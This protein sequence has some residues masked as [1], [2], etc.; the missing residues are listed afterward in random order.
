MAEENKEVLVPGQ[1]REASKETQNVELDETRVREYL[2]TKYGIEDDPETFKKKRETWTQAETE[3]PKYQGALKQVYDY[4][5]LQANQ[6]ASTA[7]GIL[8]EEKL[9]QKALLDPYGATKEYVEYRDKQYNKQVEEREERLL[10]RINEAIGG[11]RSAEAGRTRLMR[12]WPEAYD[13]NSELHKLGKSIYHNELSP[14]VRS[15]PDS[16][17]IAAE[18]AAARLGLAPKGKRETRQVRD[19]ED[20]GSQNIGRQTRKPNNTEND[21]SSRLS[22]NVKKMLSRMDVDPKTY[23]LANQARRNRQNLRKEDD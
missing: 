17:V 6:P 8:D 12:D 21:D 1:H 23:T 9:R 11:A 2:K 4:L 13:E 15:L 7:E 22:P 5:T 16:F 19:V 18:M 3:L 10:R 20:V 14:T